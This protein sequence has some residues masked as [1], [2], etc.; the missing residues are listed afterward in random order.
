MGQD[1]KYFNKKQQKK[2]SQQ[3]GKIRNPDPNSRPP[4]EKPDVHPDSESVQRPQRP[5]NP[6]VEP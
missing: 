3:P 1:A 2:S 4:V 5:N 6:E